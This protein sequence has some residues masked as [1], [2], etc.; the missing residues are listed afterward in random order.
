[1]GEHVNTFNKGM[2]SDANVLYQPD[3]TYRYMKNCSL[4]SQDGNNFVIKDCMGNTKLFEI[5]V[6]YKQ[7]TTGT[8]NTVTYDTLP[9]IIG[10]ISFPN[11]LIVFSTNAEG[12][13]INGDPIPGYGEIGEL[14]YTT[15]GEGIQP[16]PV[17]GEDNTGYVPLYHSA[18]LNF[19]KLHQI[20]GFA[21]EEND[22]IQRVYWT[23]N[24]N[25]PRVF[26]VANPIFKTYIGSGSLQDG[27]MYMVTEGV[28][29]Y[30]VGSGDYYGPSIGA[31]NNI[32]GNI[33]TCAAPNF[34]YTGMLSPSPVQ[35]V[36]EYYPEELLSFTPDRALGNIKFKQYGS[37]SK[38]C[39]SKM[40]FYRLTKPS[41]GISTTWS[42]G[43][44]PIHVGTDNTLLAVPANSYFDF[45]GGGSSTAL[46]NS[47]RS[48]FITIDNIDTNYD[49]IEVAC[50]EFD[51]LVDVPRVIN[52]VSIS[53]ITG[54][55]MD[56]EDTGGTNYG[57][58]T[59]DDITLFPASIL[60]CKTMTTNKNYIL[61]GN[62]TERTELDA[63]DNATVA[64]SQITHPMMIHE[65]ENGAIG[66]AQ[67]CQNILSYN[68]VSPSTPLSNPP[69]VDGIAPYTQWV[70][71]GA[72]TVNDY[73]TY[74]GVDYGN[75]LTLYPDGP[76]FVGAAGVFNYTITEAVPGTVQ[77]RPCVSRNRYTNSSGYNVPDYIKFTDQNAN[78]W[79][80]K[81]P[82]VASH[83]KGYWSKETYRIGIL[84]FDLKGNPFY[85][86]HLGDYTFNDIPSFPLMQTQVINSGGDISWYL[87]QYGININGLRIPKSIVGQ[88][89][90]FSIVRAERDKSIMTMGMLMQTGATSPGGT[91]ISSLA[92]P[93]IQNNESDVQNAVDSIYTLICPDRLAD[94]PIDN[95]IAGS[96][97]VGSHF[98]I[99]RLLVGSDYM[100]CSSD[101]KNALETKYF[102]ETWDAIPIDRTYQINALADI[103][104]YQN[105]SNFGPGNYLYYNVSRF[106]VAA[107]TAKDTSCY[108]GAVKGFKGAEGGAG[109]RT[110]ISISGYPWGCDL[111]GVAGYMALGSP[112][113]ELD[114]KMMVTVSIDK[115][116]FYGGQ[117][118]E[119]LANTIYI[120]TGHYQPITAQVIADTC[121]TG[122][123]NSYSYLEFNG[124][125]IWGGDCFNCLIDYG[126]TLYNSALGTDPLVYKTY[127]WGIKFACQCNSN[128]Q[129]RRGRT[130]GGNRMYSDTGGTTGL[131]YSP[132]QLEG[133]SYNK[134]YSSEGL[135]FAYPALPVNY[136]SE[137]QYKYRV[138]FGGQ[139]FPGELVDS[140]RV[141][142]VNDYKDTDGQGGEINNLKTKDGRTIVWQNRIISTV[143]I[144]EREVL[145]GSTGTPTTLGTGGVVDRFDPIN[146][147]FGNQ[148]QWGV[149]ETEYG[150]AWFDMRRKAFLAMDFGAGIQE[151]SQIEGLKGFFDEIILEV[152]GASSPSTDILNSQ[153]YDKTSDRPL[154]GTGI[155]GVYDPKFKTTYLT[156]KFKAR[157][158]LGGGKTSYINKD[159]T[160]M[161]Y[162][163]GKFFIGFSDWTPSIAHNHN[164]TVFSVNRPNN[165]TKYY[166]TG[167]LSTDFVQGDQV[168]YDN[169][170]YV[171]ISPV[172][173]ASY[174]GAANQIPDYVGSTYWY[175]TSKTNEIYAHNQPKA[176]GQD[177]APDYEYSKFFNIVVDNE[178]RF[179]INPKT[180]NPFN[181]LTMEQVGNNVNVTDVYTYS[182][183]QS[184]QDTNISATS[185]FYRWIWDRITSSL[186]LSSTGRITDNYLE[187]RL[188]KKNWSIQAYDR[189]KD[190]KILQFVKS[191][192]QEKR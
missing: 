128:Y 13:D 185:K 140:Y 121:D 107:V 6:R 135:Q 54:T 35:K 92:G 168:G 155:T 98:V 191:L 71:S 76:V 4:I 84:F 89:S 58:L 138:R 96:N 31:P 9:T 21:Y 106:Q 15:Y 73:V 188:Y 59:L 143:P 22:S 32:L 75:D 136:S 102:E 37:G 51:Q 137:G 156:F 79:S 190:V 41:E 120:S 170:E 186:P 95:Y 163:P 70:V 2:T 5:N 91:T 165:K 131:A 112:H 178:V 129:L 117:T 86:R 90:G 43:S 57:E 47:E 93:Y 103:P 123:I 53:A 141:F 113:V 62:T 150:F 45:T 40:Y 99:P 78:Q 14:N 83:V 16:I 172:T 149:V 171:C 119:A 160:V 116:T 52:I 161:Y 184:A 10:F 61:I 66:S 7:L 176:L 63:F 181:V 88:I 175:L 25:E 34:T 11:K 164:Q 39:G 158:S 101:G 82:A 33:F 46:L 12:I 1:M 109:L 132:A 153:T 36:I 3:G 115:T 139:K 42:Y 97:I 29:E 108:A 17:F 187:V 20:E 180:Q 130:L 127:S 173:I 144:L 183:Y 26:N 167:M 134:G 8:P 55:S 122:N 182:R 100:K 19:T 125:N 118:D 65:A 179:I 146:S 154:M 67:V 27:K 104:E 94:Y 145:A 81:N 44:S 192:F 124:V 80:Y 147:Y 56:I 148:H 85:V 142:N 166:G 152:L 111:D 157:T 30:P 114:Y 74:N 23:D 28:I 77:V 68:D 169:K 151:V 126:H 38:Y 69:T 72:T 174:P 50:A 133:F 60:T 159:F 48:V 189:S 110:L 24:Y 177:P 49:T 162:H 18:D 64:I 105:I 87:N